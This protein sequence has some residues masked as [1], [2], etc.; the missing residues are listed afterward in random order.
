MEVLI[1]LAFDDP[2]FT[3]GP[4]LSNFFLLHKYRPPVLKYRKEGDVVSRVQ[5][6]SYQILYR[7]HQRSGN[8]HNFKE[9]LSRPAREKMGKAGMPTKLERRYGD[10]PWVSM[11]ELSPPT[12]RGF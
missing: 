1:M 10:P 11:K 5:L 4:Q 7:E 6:G 2:I 9:A 8:Y 3:F 12:R